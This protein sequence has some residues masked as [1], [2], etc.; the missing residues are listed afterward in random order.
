V[1][2]VHIVRETPELYAAIV[3]PY[4]DA[5][6]ASRTQWYLSLSP[7]PPY[8]PT[9]HRVSDILS[10]AA[11]AS[12]V[13]YHSPPDEPHGFVVLPDMKWDTVTLGA[14]YLVAIAARPAMRSLRDITRTHL[15][16]LRAIRAA[17]RRVVRERWGLAPTE[18]RM[19]VHYQPSYCELRAAGRGD[20]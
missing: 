19:F 1:Q 18:L 14:L 17:A 20:G 13:L 12:K 8:H 10:G 15:P 7:S 9:P 2:Q 3:K 16:M 11:E 4:I 6:P 5:F